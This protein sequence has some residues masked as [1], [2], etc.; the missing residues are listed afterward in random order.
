[1]KKL[2]LYFILCLNVVACQKSDHEELQTASNQTK[3]KFRVKE[4][5]GKNDY[6]GDF[7][8][9]FTYYEEKVD[10]AIIRNAA[11]DTIAVLT[12]SE[13]T[14]SR[15]YYIADLIPSIDPDSIRKLEDKYGEL[16]KDSIPLMTRNLFSMKTEYN[17]QIVAAQEFFYYRPREDVGTGASFNNKYLNN[18]RLRYIYEYNLNGSLKICRMFYD[19]FEE[20]PDD[21]A[22]FNRTIYKAVFSYDNAGKLLGIDWYQ[23]DERYQTTEDYRLTEQYR[24]VYSGTNLTS[25]QGDKLEMQYHYANQ[26]LIRIDRNGRTTEYGYN[27]EGLLQHIGQMDGSYMDVTYEAGHGNFNLFTPLSEQNFNI[28]YIR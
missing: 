17:D 5:R 8:M 15:T 19:V 25:L 12:V 18:K 21:N 14:D 28:P 4:I 27:A 16:A 7:S 11:Q 1:M 24:P 10:S 3:N 6:W 20:D 13:K 2:I 23:G 26:L 22:Q 9:T